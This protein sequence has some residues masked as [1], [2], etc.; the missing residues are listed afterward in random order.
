MTLEVRRLR[1][2]DDRSDF[3]SGSVELDR[4]FI[5]FAGQNQFRHHLG[6]TYVA[7]EGSRVHG[8]VTLAAAELEITGLPAKQRKGLPNYPLPAL[9]IAR[10]AV[11]EASQ[12]RVIGGELL[13]AAFLIAGELAQKVGCIGLVVD[14]KPG[15][16][17]FYADYGFEHVEVVQGELGFRPTLQ[18]M[19][20][21]LRAIPS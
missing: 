8:F 5:R 18:T 3:H 20:L 14:A 10:L 21:P 7:V 13:K 2:E 1:E 15:A 11:D 9:R 12:R 17:R 19:F 16:S 4:F 6:V